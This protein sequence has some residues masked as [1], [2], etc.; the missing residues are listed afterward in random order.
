[1]A[2]NE[3]L[4]KFQILKSTTGE[5]PSHQK[6]KMIPFPVSNNSTSCLAKEPSYYNIELL[7]KFESPKSSTWKW[8]YTVGEELFSWVQSCSICSKNF[9]GHLKFSRGGPKLIL[10]QV[11]D[12]WVPYFQRNESLKKSLNWLRLNTSGLVKNIWT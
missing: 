8:Q 9:Q 4:T 10:N 6:V 7:T 1:M 12:L 3:L 11:P 2:R 5:R